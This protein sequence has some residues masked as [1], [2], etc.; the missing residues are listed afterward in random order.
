MWNACK[1][2]SRDP[3]ELLEDLGQPDSLSFFSVQTPPLSSLPP[4]EPQWQACNRACPTNVSSLIVK[5]NSKISAKHRPTA[6]SG[7]LWREII[8]PLKLSCTEASW[9]P[10][11]VAK[12]S[13]LLDHYKLAFKFPDRYKFLLSKNKEKKKVLHTGQIWK[14]HRASHLLIIQSGP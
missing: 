13:V 1:D 9:W 4:M 11:C 7:L 10:S 6:R 3:S 8:R 5:W 2:I 12:C 14:T